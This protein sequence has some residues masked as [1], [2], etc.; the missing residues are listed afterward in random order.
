[1][2]FES[3]RNSVGNVD[4]LQVLNALWRGTPVPDDVLQEAMPELQGRLR[5]AFTPVVSFF[6]RVRSYM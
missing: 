3:F 5:Y 2:S 4:A 1:M 6:D